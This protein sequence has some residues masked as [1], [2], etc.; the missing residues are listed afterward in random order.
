MFALPKDSENPLKVAARVRD[1]HE[2]LIR[3]SLN[4]DGSDSEEDDDDDD[5]EEDDDV[6]VGDHPNKGNNLQNCFVFYCIVMV[7]YQN[8]L[9]LLGLFYFLTSY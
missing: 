3:G 7:T 2:S 9:V 4:L 5:E 6:L 8:Q 1:E